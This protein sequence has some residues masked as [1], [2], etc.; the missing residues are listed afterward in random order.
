MWLHLRVF[1]IGLRL[2]RLR[3]HE[4]VL[5]NL[6]LRQQ[7]LVWERT[8]DGPADDKRSAL[9]VDRGARL[10]GLAEAL[11]AGGTGNRRALASHGLAAVL[12]LAQPCTRRTAPDRC[13]EPS[14]D[15]QDGSRE[16]DLRRRPDRRGAHR[17]ASGCWGSRPAPSGPTRS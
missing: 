6:V 12:D 8:S 3:E 1:L 16:P 9:L 2:I 7:L 5:E 4:L 10:A 11:R 15:P 13:G 17:S 14:P